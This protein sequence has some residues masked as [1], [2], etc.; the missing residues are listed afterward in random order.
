[1]RPIEIYPFYHHHVDS[2]HDEDRTLTILVIGNRR[3]VFAM[4][5]ETREDESL[6]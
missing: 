6:C 4:L 2:F 1:M 3:A 5:V